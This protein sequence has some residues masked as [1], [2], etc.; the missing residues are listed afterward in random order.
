MRLCASARAPFRLSARWRAGGPTQAPAQERLMAN[1]TK[2]TAQ[3]DGLPETEGPGSVPDSPLLDLAD[4]AV[5][6]LIRSAKK[7]GYVTNEQINAV[8]P[9]DEANSEQIEN[10]LSMFN[11]MGV[12]VVEKEEAEAREEDAAEEP[13]EEPEGEKELV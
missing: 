5:K 13:E 6:K 8:L 11:D 1:R 12:N 2:V 10:L 3:K 4:G 9:S 7:R